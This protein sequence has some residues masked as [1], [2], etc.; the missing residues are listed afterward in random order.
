MTKFQKDVKLSRTIASREFASS[1]A[2][3]K[4][5]D[6]MCHK[7]QAKLPDSAKKVELC[8]GDVRNPQSIKDAMPGIDCIFHAAALKQIPSCEFFPMQ[9]VRINIVGTDNVLHAAIEAS[10]KRIVCLPTG[11]AVYPINAMAIS[12][13]G[14]RH[15][16][17]CTYCCR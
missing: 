1:P 5:Q 4:K 17:K 7:L 13:D 3:I 9:A 10:V 12:K 6:D 8:I 16:C 15:L 14:T 11:K 2:T